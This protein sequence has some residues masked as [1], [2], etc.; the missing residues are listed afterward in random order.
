MDWGTDFLLVDD[1]VVFT[2]DGDMTIV[3]GAAMVA[4]DIDQTIKTAVGAL[5]WDRRTGSAMPLMLN[6]SESE[7]A[8]IIAE[9]ERVAIADARVDPDSVKAYR[10]GPGKFRLEFKPMARVKPETLEYDLTKGRGE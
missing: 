8:S 4:Q 6:D 10:T 5:Y 2:S 7:A 9:L 1:D 3:S